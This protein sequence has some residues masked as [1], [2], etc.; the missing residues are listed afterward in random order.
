MSNSSTPR[1][2]SF[3]ESLRPKVAVILNPI[4]RGLIK[5]HLTA[6]VLTFAGLLLAVAVGIA[7]ANG[8]MLLAGI[9]MLLSG[10]MDA[11]DG[12]VARQSGS[13]NN[14]FGA[15]FDSTTDRYAEG[16]VLLGLS[17]YGLSINDQRIV[18]LSFIALWGSILISYTRARAEGL[19]IECKI[20]LFTRMER[21]VVVSAMLVLNQI[22]I[23]LII[24]AIFTHFTSLQRVVFVYRATHPRQK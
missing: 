20:G 9:L 5:L 24:L 6:D 7:A 2:A 12:A 15:F 23:G 21:F 14:K 1:P 19:G 11:L 8:Q 18:L 17:I 16:F 3:S 4:A 10:P 22:L 13:V